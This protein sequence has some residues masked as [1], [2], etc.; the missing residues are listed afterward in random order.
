MGSAWELSIFGLLFK[1]DF[2]QSDERTT[3]TEK[4]HRAAQT[5]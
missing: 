5:Q 1:L 4:A 2:K 3:I